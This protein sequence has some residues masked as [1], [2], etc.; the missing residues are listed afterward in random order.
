M[1]GKVAR[2]AYPG[3]T[4][5][6]DRLSEDGRWLHLAPP[7]VACAKA[8][9]P[10]EGEPATA[11]E[12]DAGN[13]GWVIRHWEGKALFEFMGTVAPDDGDGDAKKKKKK[14]TT[15]IGLAQDEVCLITAKAK[16]YQWIQSNGLPMPKDNRPI[17]KADIGATVYAKNGVGGMEFGAKY[18]LQATQPG[19]L[20]GSPVTQYL[21]IDMSA[22]RDG[23]PVL[24]S[25]GSTPIATAAAN[26]QRW[27]PFAV[28]E[29]TRKMAWKELGHGDAQITSGDDPQTGGIQACLRV[30]SGLAGKFQLNQLVNKGTEMK[31]IDGSGGT[32]LT[33]VVRPPGWSAAALAA[34]SADPAVA[35]TAD[36]MFRG[37]SDGKP[38]KCK[39]K[40]S[41]G[42]FN[43]Q[44]ARPAAAD[45]SGFTDSKLGRN[46]LGTGPH[47]NADLSRRPEAADGQVY[48]LK[49]K[50]RK[51]CELF[52]K[53]YLEAQQSLPD[54]LGTQDAA[55]GAG[56]AAT[57]QPSPT[58]PCPS[59]DESSAPVST[60]PSL[61]FP[62]AQ[63]TTSARFEFGPTTHPAA[64]AAVGGFGLESRA[65]RP[66]IS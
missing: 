3:D 13:E 64:A 45:P 2:G 18:Q 19:L 65:H 53:L 32:M 36:H 66:S 6:V 25:F 28:P 8:V 23:T 16:L 51:T 26:L 52:Q 62:A 44:G 9:K 56:K 22:A 14:T 24:N 35:A 21:L 59:A 10:A 49:F 40:A 33:W 20:Q 54:V 11:N 17:N 37:G 58:S 34:P 1:V 43:K 15:T 63:A 12:W 29:V 46:W 31:L 42:I 57:A 7:M 5:L 41:G 39:P 48:G 4:I 50:S 38:T 27:D 60:T 55:M 47:T 30:K 61:A